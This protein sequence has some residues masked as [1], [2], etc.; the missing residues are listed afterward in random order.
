MANYKKRPPPAAEKAK[1]RA[2]REHGMSLQEISKKFHRGLSTVTR[3]LSEGPPANKVALANK[4]LSRVEASTPVD[5][6]NPLEEVARSLVGVLKERMPS[7]R[8]LHVDLAKGDVE[9]EVVHKLKFK[10]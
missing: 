3:V 9:M 6:V 1:I 10:V 7:I 4:A 2:A 5:Y 8:L